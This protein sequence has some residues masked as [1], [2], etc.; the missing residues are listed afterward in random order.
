[1]A[2]HEE[3]CRR[4]AA[5]AAIARL[6]AEPARTRAQLQ[7]PLQKTQPGPLVVSPLAA[8]KPRGDGGRA[9]ISESSGAPAGIFICEFKCGFSG[10]YQ[11]VA[12]H[13]TTHSKPPL[14]A[15]PVPP[16]TACD[17]PRPPSQPCQSRTRFQ[18][19]FKCGY[20]GPYQDV[21][22]HEETCIRRPRARR[23]V[24]DFTPPPFAPPSPPCENPTPL[25]IEHNRGAGAAMELRGA[26]QGAAK[27]REGEGEDADVTGV[28]PDTMGTF[29]GDCT[30]DLMSEMEES[31]LSWRSDADARH[32]DPSGHL[33][34]PHGQGGPHAHSHAH[35]HAQ[36]AA[37]DGTHAS[38][39]NSD[40]RARTGARGGAEK[41]DGKH[42]QGRQKASGSGGSR[43]SSSSGG[44]S[45]SA[46]ASFDASLSRL[47][48]KFKS[49]SDDER[50]A[51]RAAAA[52]AAS[53]LSRHTR[54]A[55][56]AHLAQ[57]LRK[58]SPIGACA[59]LSA[60]IGQ[61]LLEEASSVS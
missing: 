31:F 36:A 60:E 51:K 56:S 42:V 46:D 27:T 57:T 48:D 40:V 61:E 25:D 23:N 7:N 17:S 34:P 6:P 33:A 15:R 2:Q 54:S 21:E 49:K 10:T 47:L 13:E 16:N 18:C 41:G 1:M 35:A 8:E 58:A 22:G 50:D 3:T 39:S 32:D 52:T 19:E 26:Q 38:A 43:P 11:E 29:A 4:G 12:A 59:Q 20:T 44:S 24:A 5:H 37:R 28:A 30:E 14:A 55:A 45:G 9:G 53:L